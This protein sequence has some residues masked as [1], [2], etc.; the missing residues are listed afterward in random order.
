M[1]LNVKLKEHKS[2]MSLTLLFA[3]ASFAILLAVL[4]VVAGVSLIMIHTGILPHSELGLVNGYQMVGLMLI[5]SVVL[6]SAFSF[7]FGRLFVKPINTIINVMNRLATG[8]FKA[9]ISF[10]SVFAKHPTVMELTDSINTMAED[11]ENT[12]V[13]RLD[14]VNNFSHEFKTPIV[15]I[16]GF[17]KLL[18]SGD[19]T[20][21]QRQEYL[22]IIEE[23]SL[24]LSD[25]ATNVLSLTRVEGQTILTGVTQFNLSEQI[26]SC[27][28]ILEN[29][30]THKALDLK[31]DFDEVEICANE[32]LL[33]QVWINIIENAVKFTP[34][35]GTV[36]VRIVTENTT[37]ADGGTVS[38][39]VENTGSYIAPENARR[40]FQK[41]YQVDKSHATPG[42]GVG[43]AVVKRVVDLHH[44][45]VWFRSENDVTAFIVK[46]PLRSG[47]S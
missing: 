31:L 28:L 9:R 18:K 25:M 5:S 4:L 44:G 14:F 6:G 15:S 2:R 47:Q 35:G 7:L 19:L 43:L 1:K 30:W 38:V 3:C 34:Y 36:S 12:E 45:L 32:E 21:E 10:G 16:A 46:L 27:F 11:L 8:D 41:F 29:K 42:N 20:E 17:A 13:L 22:N 24:R 26:R 33:R 40:V 37:E 39:T 23:E